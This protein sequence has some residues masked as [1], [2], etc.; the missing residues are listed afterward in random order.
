MNLNEVDSFIFPAGEIQ[1]NI[2]DKNRDNYIYT[3]ITCSDD[4]I[5]Y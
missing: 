5:K 1:V 4:I 3:S 2:N